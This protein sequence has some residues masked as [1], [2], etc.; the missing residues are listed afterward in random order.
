VPPRSPHWHTSVRLASG[1]TPPPGTRARASY[2]RYHASPAGCLAQQLCLFRYC[3]SGRRST[4][5]LL[6]LDASAGAVLAREVD[7]RTMQVLSPLC[8]PLH[9]HQLLSPGDSKLVQEQIQIPLR[10]G[11]LRFSSQAHIKPAVAV[12]SWLQLF[13]G[14]LACSSS[15]VTSKQLLTSPDDMPT[16]ACP[17]S[18]TLLA[19]EIQNLLRTLAEDLPADCSPPI[20]RAAPWDGLLRACPAQ[21]P[22]P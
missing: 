19:A 20:I 14:P 9:D 21:R 13:R 5:S 4:Y 18:M 1:L 16:D 12:D 11:G 6:A 7:T 3:A 22:I 2:R 15:T 17:R 8:G 10:W